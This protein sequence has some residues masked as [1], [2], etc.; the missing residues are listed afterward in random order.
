MALPE[1]EENLAEKKVS[2]ENGSV[3]RWRKAKF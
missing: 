2:P 1:Q 3:K